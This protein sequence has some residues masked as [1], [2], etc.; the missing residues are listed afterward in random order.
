[1]RSCCKNK[2]NPTFLPVIPAEYIAELVDNHSYYVQQFAQQVWLRTKKKCSK[3]I[4]DE[5]I[6]SL[7]YQLS[8]L[9][10]SQIETL[11]ST[12]INFLKAVLEGETAF[13]SQE[14]LKKYRLGTSANLTKI[15]GTLI[16]REIIDN[17][18]HKVVILDPFFKLWLKEDFFKIVDKR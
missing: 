1:M 3:S 15:K 8:L 2:L 9:F 6:Q 4:I 16:S 18:A 17:Y 14:N 12:Q 11:T 7:K 10:V 13:A 5:A